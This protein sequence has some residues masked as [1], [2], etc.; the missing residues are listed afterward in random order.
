MHSGNRLFNSES[1]YESAERD[2]IVT[3]LWFISLV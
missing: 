1:L 3:V 2:L